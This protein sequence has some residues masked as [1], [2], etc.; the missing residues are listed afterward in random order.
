M[1][2]GHKKKINTIKKVLDLKQT[3]STAL[4]DLPAQVNYVR[5][6]D[7]TLKMSH[8]NTLEFLKGIV[9]DLYQD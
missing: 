4:L 2:S 6:T 3:G 8:R 7:K 5:E 1:I 9:T